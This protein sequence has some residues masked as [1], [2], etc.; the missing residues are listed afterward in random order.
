MSKVG[1]AHGPPTGKHCREV[2]HEGASTTTDER[3]DIL[4][5]LS[6]IKKLLRNMD[7]SKGNPE[8]T[9]AGGTE[10]DS[11]ES[12]QEVESVEQEGALDS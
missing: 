6:D 7:K 12:A 3:A 2:H 9:S 4:R 1:K 11:E 5:M 8:G 10:G